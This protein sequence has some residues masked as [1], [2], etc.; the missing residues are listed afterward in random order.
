MYILRFI[1]AVLPFCENAN[2]AENQAISTR[3]KPASCIRRRRVMYSKA[4]D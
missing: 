3:K 4:I 2:E 1:Y